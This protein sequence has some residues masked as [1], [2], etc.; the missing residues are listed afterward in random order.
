M[1]AFFISFHSSFELEQVSKSPWRC[2]RASPYSCT[3]FVAPP[4]SGHFETCSR[5]HPVD[6]ADCYR[7]FAL[8]RNPVVFGLCTPYSRIVGKTLPWRL[9]IKMNQYFWKPAMCLAIGMAVS[10][11]AMADDTVSETRPVNP[12]ISRVILDGTTSLQLRQGATPTLVIYGD[13]DEIKSVTT[14]MSGDT[15]RIENEGTYIMHVPKFRVELTLPNLDRFTSSGIGSAQVVGFSGD[16]LQINI[17]GTGSV[18]VNAH[19]KQVTI[20]SAGI[21]SANVN[22]GDSDKI[23][24]NAPGAGHVVLVGQTRELISK[25]DGVGGLDARE[26]KAD[27]V[28]A[29]LNGVGS[30]K[31]YAKKSANM[32]LHGMGSITV[33]G[34][35]ATRNSEVS[36]FGKINWE[37]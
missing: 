4:S 24:V 27:N 29:Y 35:P 11:A 19:Y 7:D 31:V 36:G 8:R 28:T 17:T 21:G 22:D 37:E 5:N 13:K 25:L 12:G 3:V 32:Y 15:L 20:R 2:C 9:E 14:G 26:L 16:S 30:A 34:N 1:A 18:N 10:G 33:Y 6:L 23:E